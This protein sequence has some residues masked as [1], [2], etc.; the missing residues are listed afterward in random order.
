MT[1]LLTNEEIEHALTMEDCIDSLREA[2]LELA[3]GRA[4]YRPRRDLLAP[5]SRPGLVRTTQ[6]TPGMRSDAA[7]SMASMRA[8]GYGL[9]SAT[10][11]RTSATG[12]SSA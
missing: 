7:A 6:R 1:L 4:A 9:R 5:T 12:T 3:Q 8:C 10:A 11:C 2:Y